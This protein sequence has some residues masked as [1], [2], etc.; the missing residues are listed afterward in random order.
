[1]S[2]IIAKIADEYDEVPYLSSAFPSS[3]PEHLQGLG[4]LFNVPGPDV[5]R[6]RVLELGCSMGG[7]IIPFAA[8]WP[9]AKVVGLDLSPTQ[10][11]S[12]QRIVEAMGLTNI[13]LRQMNLM[14]VRP[15][16]GQFDYIICHGV[17]SWVPADVQ[18][19]ILR[20][21]SE[22]LAPEGLAYVSYNTYPGWKGKEILRD[23]MMLRGGH[24]ATASER[25]AYARGMIDFLEK[26]AK[27]GSMLATALAGHAE[28]I[29]NGSPHYLLHEYLEACNAP[30]Y[31][32]D[33]IAAAGKHGLGYVAESNAAR[34]VVSHH[35]AEVERALLS[36]LKDQIDIE[37]YLD[38]IQDS[39]F[40]TT[41]LAH[42]AHME[43][44]AYAVPAAGFRGCHVA[45][46]RSP[47]K[48]NGG[49]PGISVHNLIVNRILAAWPSTVP[50]DE[51]IDASKREFAA[52]DPAEIESM[53]LQSLRMV[54]LHGALRVRRHPVVVGANEAT[55][56]R[57]VAGMAELV[58]ISG[59]GLPQVQLF[60]A[61]HEAVSLDVVSQR[62][63][64]RLDGTRD[65]AELCAAM[66]EDA[67]KG[68]LRF[69]RD[70]V[71]VTDAVEIEHCVQEHVGNSLRN[72][73]KLA[74]LA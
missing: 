14:D 69:T 55:H 36:E 73:R 22:N 3:C 29:R 60:N 23:A 41:I 21:C 64:P 5:E 17:Y 32:K 38:F 35:G 25:L 30:C 12:G 50:V 39:A 61:W 63:I 67:A 42:K 19:T 16:L 2:D 43:K 58:A 31:F 65:R 57:V 9:Q 51:L 1:M 26:W 56:P 6:A 7:N 45:A 53:V 68:V 34:M 72:L 27:P 62:L 15:A 46:G 40:R 52:H 48:P 71:Q 70:G 49:E 33:F 37:Q 28:T 18:D 20:V 54:F 4:H 8:R 66:V 74:I 59:G 44:V 11:A 13:E 47:G 10:I 24:R